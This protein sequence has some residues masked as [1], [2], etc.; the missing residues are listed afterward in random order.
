MQPDPMGAV[1]RRSNPNP[2]NPALDSGESARSSVAV[3][4]EAYQAFQLERRVDGKLWLVRTD[5]A[6]AVDVVRCFPWSEPRRFLSFRNA[7]GEEQAFIRDL[8][9]LDPRSRGVA[10][11]TLRRASFVLD[12]AEILEVA[13]DFELRSW[14]VRAANGVRSFQ[15]ALDSWPEKLPDGSLLLED[16]Y[17]DLYRVP[18]P[19]ALDA[20]SRKLL[21]AFVD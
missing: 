8:D 2:S 15:T 11:E 1:A 4:E 14:R 18:A 3:P 10:A 20:K 21:W 7:E 19:G 16:V 13:E 6:V 9:E 17:G 5:G 12:I